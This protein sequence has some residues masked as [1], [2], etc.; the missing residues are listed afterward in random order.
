MKLPVSVVI[1]TANES[2]SLPDCLKA[3]FSFTDDVSIVDSG[4][5][6]GTVEIAR[7]EGAGVYVNRFVGFGTQRNWAID[8]VQHRF[9]WVLHLDADERPTEAFLLEIKSLLEQ[10]REE[11]GFFVPSKLMFGN[12]WLK[13]ASGFPVYQV[14][15]F[16][17][18][19]LRFA[20]HG[21]GQRE[22]TDG[23]LGYMKEP[24]L[25][26]A[27]SKGLKDWFIKHA[28]YA[29]EEAR[30]SIS[31]TNSMAQSLV[32]LF[33][34]DPVIRRRSLKS[35]SYHVPFR[36]S[37]R[38][39]YTLLIKRAILDGRAGIAYAKMI[40]TYEA[41]IVAYIQATQEGLEIDFLEKS[42]PPSVSDLSV[43]STRSLQQK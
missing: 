31:D 30:L 13:H 35:L 8:H 28:R 39:A 32:N 12:R 20:D 27:F 40:A 23:T 1:L 34:R 14:R 38:F 18:D 25:H 7:R 22:V 10:P 9:D 33:D 29:A 42:P 21:H 3:V 26:F 19:R 4:S 6:D 2:Q 43:V 36:P 16:H 17:R 5:E 11:A 15:L 37:L 24:Y 41:M